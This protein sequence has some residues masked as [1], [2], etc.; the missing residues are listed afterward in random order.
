MINSATQRIFSILF[1]PNILLH[2][3]KSQF[4]FLCWASK[5]FSPNPSLVLSLL[6]EI[7]FKKRY[8]TI[9]ILQYKKLIKRISM[10]LSNVL[11]NIGAAKWQ[12]F[13]TVFTFSSDHCAQVKAE[14][15]SSKLKYSKY[16]K[17][18]FLHLAHSLSSYCFTFPLSYLVI[19]FNVFLSLSLVY[20][21]CYPLKWSFLILCCFILCWLNTLTKY[22]QVISNKMKRKI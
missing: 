18:K 21:T 7:T 3:G 5:C 17:G 19:H 15:K 8:N 16:S 11:S 22:F 1:V 10:I 2:W 4:Y 12:T 9:Q 6:R 20:N 13:S 14:A